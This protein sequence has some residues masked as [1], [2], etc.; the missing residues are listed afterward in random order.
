MGLPFKS[1]S[2]WM[3][4]QPG[5]EME[6][7]W[8]EVGHRRQHLTSSLPFLNFQR[9]PPEDRIF[10]LKGCVGHLFKKSSKKILLFGAVFVAKNQMAIWLQSRDVVHCSFTERIY[11]KVQGKK[12]SQAPQGLNMG[13]S[14]LSKATWSLHCYFHLIL[15]LIN[16]LPLLTCTIHDPPT[17]RSSYQSGC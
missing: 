8:I 3:E 12:H 2:C 16:R 13:R 1:S 15:L 17:P 10:G 6:A 5:Q 7:A 11:T 4:G 14:C 9:P